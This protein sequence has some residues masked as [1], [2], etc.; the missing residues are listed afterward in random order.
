[1]IT[2]NKT[3]V[4]EYTYRFEKRFFMILQQIIIPI[5]PQKT[6]TTLS[7]S[8][9]LKIT[10]PIKSLH[11]KKFIEAI[12]DSEIKVV[13]AAPTDPKYGINIRFSTIFAIALMI[14]LLRK[15]FS[16]LY[17]SKTQ[18]LNN[19][20]NVENNIATLKIISGNCASRY[21]LPA[22]IRTA[23]LLN[24]ITPTIDGI[25]NIINALATLLNSFS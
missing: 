2:D 10:F 3:D 6:E 22:I 20:L 25:I 1:M 23:S 14:E 16:R 24:S 19:P 15:T 21:L 17:G 12:I 8:G 13:K 7:L 5:L 18:L 9:L 4:T 11:P